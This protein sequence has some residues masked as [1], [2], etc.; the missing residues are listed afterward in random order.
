VYSINEKGKKG[1]YLDDTQRDAAIQ[2]QGK[3]IADTCP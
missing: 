2:Q 1:G 3:E